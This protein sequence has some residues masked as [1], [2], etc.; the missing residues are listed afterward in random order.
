MSRANIAAA[1]AWAPECGWTFAASAPKSS[2]TRAMANR[3]TTSTC[4]Q[5]P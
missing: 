3:S 1:L 2:F 4:S 5:P